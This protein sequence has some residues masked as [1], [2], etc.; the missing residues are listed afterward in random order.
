MSVIRPVI[1]YAWASSQGSDSFLVYIHYRTIVVD[2]STA[3]I[4][5]V[6]RSDVGRS[7]IVHIGRGCDI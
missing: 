6:A 5:V 3:Y 4:A 2:G 1:S 7:W